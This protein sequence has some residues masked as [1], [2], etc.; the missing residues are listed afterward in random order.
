MSQSLEDPLDRLLGDWAESREADAE[1][2]RELTEKVLL[3]EREQRNEIIEASAADVQPLV[4]RRSWLCVGPGSKL[5]AEIQLIVGGGGLLMLLV[6]SAALLFYNL[7]DESTDGL[8]QGLPVV[9]ESKGNEPPSTSA[10][11]SIT[12]AAKQA[13]LSEANTVFENQLTW[14]I[15]GE[16]EVLMGVGEFTDLSDDEFLFVRIVVAERAAPDSPWSTVWQTNLL[17]RNEAMVEVSTSEVDL[18][19]WTCR[20]PDGAVAVDMELTL[21]NKTGLQ[22]SSNAIL[23]A[24]FPKQV[25]CSHEKGMERCIFQTVMPLSSSNK[26]L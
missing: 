10:I 14:I 11:D 8:Q 16:R 20:L 2:I 6:L 24:G 3:V 13:L 9:V 22:A 21:D 23:Q 26:L 15:D 18:A 25:A 12:L 5:N 17:S 4:E 19:L 1:R 7:T